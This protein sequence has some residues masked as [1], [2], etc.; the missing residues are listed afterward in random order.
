MLAYIYHKTIW[1]YNT[2]NADYNKIMINNILNKNQSSG[3]FRL[4]QKNIIEISNEKTY[5][6]YIIY[7]NQ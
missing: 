5:I 1:K 6:N 7:I 2:T 3:L 4:Y